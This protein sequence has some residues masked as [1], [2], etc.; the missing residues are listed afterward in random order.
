MLSLLISLGI[1]ALAGVLYDVLRPI[2]YR[3]R[4]AAAAVIDVCFCL[5]AG[6]LT[7]LYGMSAESGRLG[8]WQMATVALGF[9]IYLYTLSKLLLPFFT[10]ISES[11]IKIYG[12]LK[13]FI[14]KVHL[15]AKNLFKNMQ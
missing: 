7:Y 2:R 5:S 6:V 11:L 14:K 12:E 15:S 10:C 3:E 9:I 4:A 13:I 1:G 8:I